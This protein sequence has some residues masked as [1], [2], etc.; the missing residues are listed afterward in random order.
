MESWRMRSLSPGL[1]SSFLQTG[2]V[3]WSS[4]Q[5]MMQGPGREWILVYQLISLL[6]LTMEA[7]LTLQLFDRLALSKVLQKQ[8]SVLHWF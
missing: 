2:Q 1:P 5:G 6:A 4:S 8:Y 3:P 7:V